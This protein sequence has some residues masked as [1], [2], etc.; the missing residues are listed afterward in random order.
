METTLEELEN[1]LELLLWNYSFGIYSEKYFKNEYTKILN[2]ME[3]I[4][5]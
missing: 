3:K 2:K 4:Q 5:C 1:D